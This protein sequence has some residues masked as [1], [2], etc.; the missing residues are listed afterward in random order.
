MP[1]PVRFPTGVCAEPLT[2]DHLTADHLPA[3][4]QER[5]SVQI[6]SITD[7]EGVDALTPGGQLSF[8]A[9][10]L[11]VVYGRN[12]SGKSS[13]TRILKQACSAR[14]REPLRGNVFE[15]RDGEPRFTIHYLVDGTRG[16]WRPDDDKPPGLHHVRVH[17]TSCGALFR[18]GENEVLYRP[19][20]LDVLERLAQVCDR[21]RAEIS[22]RVE[23][24]AATR[25]D[26]SALPEG[27]AARKFVANLSVRTSD[28]EIEAAAEFTKADERRF[29]ELAAILSGNETT[30]LR[31]TEE[32]RVRRLESLHRR[33]G[34][35]EALLGAEATKRL[36]SLHSDF[37]TAR[38]AVRVAS[39]QALGQGVLP[40]VGGEVWR[41]LWEAARRYSTEVAYPDRRFP[42]VDDDAVCVLC[43]QPLADE[44]SQRLVRIDEFVRR[45]V[46]ENADAAA[47]ALSQARRQLG[48]LRLEDPDDA[49]L[50][51]EI[52]SAD[53][54]LSAA[55]REYF[56]RQR[57]RRLQ[58]APAL[59]GGNWQDVDDPPEPV[60]IRLEGL[61]ARLRERVDSMRSAEDE[62]ARGV[63]RNEVRELE[64]RRS[65]ASRAKDI[66]AERDSLRELSV[67]KK[68]LADTSTNAI[69]QKSTELTRRFITDALVERFEEEARGLGLER[70]VLTSAGGKKGVVKHRVDLDGAVAPATPDE[71]L[72]DGELSALGLAGFL[73]E[74]DESVT[75]LIVDD[76][77]TSLDHDN[78]LEVARRLASLAHD[79]Q[80]VVFTHD[81]V[82]ALW[83]S[84]AAE[85]LGVE[86]TGRELQ[87]A[88]Q[89]GVCREELPWVAK[90]IKE[91]AGEL[92]QTVARARKLAQ[93]G[94]PEME[95]VVRD[96][97][98]RLRTMW[99][100]A[101]EES[102][103][104]PIVTRY[105][106][107]IHATPVVRLAGFTKEDAD[108]LESGFSKASDLGE[109]HD[110][111]PA[112][113]L[114][115]P[116]PDE[117]AEDLARLREWSDRMR[118][119]MAPRGGR[120]K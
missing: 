32:L 97:Y 100:R 56:E 26:P 69:T 114:H 31:A 2:A 24:L 57:A 9:E 38:E 55:C 19:H 53:E 42:V 85:D 49:A 68:A 23:S 21:V 3:L 29:G 10:G 64:A 5:A 107:E 82:F 74:L 47:S 67:L 62:E 109:M 71:I 88:P 15:V 20:G 90:T 14:V 35:V 50:W 95:G 91:R 12:R 48:E 54:S 7:V 75:S 34:E 105:S 72:S 96:F 92:E 119:M 80:V 84:K 28:Q 112:V 60:G 66:T 94:A 118:K 22:A 25:F 46:Q 98:K 89:P 18:R 4:I 59:D 37:V 44:A 103:L 41:A 78:R 120:K 16:A 13:Y 11:T 27:T 102:L 113:N 70:V 30:K 65:L 104:G 39:Q 101:V 117:M 43:E 116:G 40:G 52:A 86:L 58:L 111:S 81:A 108:Q 79:R 106:T 45:D 77:V 99:E 63:L 93:E 33:V 87:L 83:L 73:A 115:L 76:P 1:G 51:D 110:E 17:D 61:L 36:G 8:G 6:L